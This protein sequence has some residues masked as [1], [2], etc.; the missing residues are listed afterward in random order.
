MK[1]DH[2]FWSIVVLYFAGELL[3]GI[4]AGIDVTFIMRNFLSGLLLYFVHQKIKWV[5]TVFIALVVVATI[6]GVVSLTMFGLV[7]GAWLLIVLT[8]L[9][10]AQLAF[11]IQLRRIDY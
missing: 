7:E 2:I 8:V 11:F 6:M 3:T 4:V 10:I 5:N 1:R 9:N